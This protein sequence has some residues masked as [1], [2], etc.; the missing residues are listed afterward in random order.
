MTQPNSSSHA[1]DP[2]SFP[3]CGKLYGRHSF[4]A[5][6]AATIG[7]KH[8]SDFYPLLH[9]RPFVGY[10]CPSQCP[11]DTLINCNP[12]FFFFLKESDS[13]RF[14]TCCALESQDPRPHSQD[15]DSNASLLGDQGGFCWRTPGGFICFDAETWWN[16]IMFCLAQAGS[17][18][19]F[20]NHQ[21]LSYILLG[22]GDK[23]QSTYALN[24]LLQTFIN[25]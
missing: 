5:Q 20:Y 23:K 25:S 15:P 14:S 10:S 19:H 2:W 3:S 12:N 21:S 18:C 24:P 11:K 4:W 9:I 17:N 22:S 7:N 6:I 1:T 16:R 13:R 8:E